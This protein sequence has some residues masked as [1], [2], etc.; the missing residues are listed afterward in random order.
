MKR[1]LYFF[2]NNVCVIKADV[3]TGVCIR[4]FSPAHFANRRLDNKGRR[5][6][7]TGLNLSFW[8]RASSIPNTVTFWPISRA[9]ARK[10]YATGE[11][12]PRKKTK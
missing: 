10:Y 5:I 9:S 6:N 11:V 8:E 7:E 4:L 2:E 3:Q 12:P 1:F